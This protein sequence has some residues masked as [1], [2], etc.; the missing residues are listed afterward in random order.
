MNNRIFKILGEISQQLSPLA[1]IL[2]NSD[3]NEVFKKQLEISKNLNDTFA[4]II[5]QQME[6]SNIMQQNKFLINL[7]KIDKSILE[8]IK[9]FQRVFNNSTFLELG[10][11]YKQLKENFEV[12][13]DFIEDLNNFS[14]KLK[15]DDKFTFD[16]K[17]EDIE[18]I[19]KKIEQKKDFTKKDLITFDRI[20]SIISL[21]FALYIYSFPDNSEYIKTQEMIKELDNK[22]SKSLKQEQYY[23][24]IKNA[25]VREQSNTKSKK[26]AEVYPNQK[27]LIIEN[28]AYWLQVEYFDEKRKETVIGWIAKKSTKKLN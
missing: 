28:K 24:V 16:I 18:E 12:D 22:F 13:K 25:E 27:L 8:N 11:T 17:Y 15:I 7:P 6:L 14:K 5:K 19:N 3:L 9:T 23:E 4:P 26:I 2:N 10:E 21:L 1:Q 20:I